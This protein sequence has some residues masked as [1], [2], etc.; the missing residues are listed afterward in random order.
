MKTHLRLPALV[1]LLL[2]LP[3]LQSA[4]RGAATACQILIDGVSYE[5]ARLISSPGFTV[6]VTRSNADPE[7]P[8]VLGTPQYRPL[9]L[10]RPVPPENTAPKDRAWKEWWDRR[11]TSP[12]PKKITLVYSGGAPEGTA[13]R[14][15]FNDAFLA[16]YTISGG[17]D[18]SPVERITVFVWRM[19]VPA[20]PSP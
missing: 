7:K 13:F 19:S 5:T 8:F 11:V 18:G 16:G 12:S 2:A 1:L 4:A 9:V 10:E 6:G 15:E 20:N 3:P 17:A 14:L